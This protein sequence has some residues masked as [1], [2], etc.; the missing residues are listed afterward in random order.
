MSE[1]NFVFGLGLVVSFIFAFYLG[2]HPELHPANR[3]NAAQVAALDRQDAGGSASA[4]LTSET[5]RTTNN[6]AIEILKTY[7]GLALQA[8]PEAD[9]WLI[10]YGHKGDK[11]HS[12]MSITP[13]KAERLLRKDLKSREDFVHSVVRVPINDNE[14]SA[15]VILSYNIGNG[16]FRN[17]TVLRELNAGNRRSAADAF[18]MW[19]KVKRSGELA[20]SSQLTKRR[21]AERALF[22]DGP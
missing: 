12:G 19:N 22:L 9:Y 6:A 2:E 4:G 16:A 10:G 11:V 3:S 21:K 1:L 18:L 15:L 8:Y 17:S 5:R 7:E 20:E 14:F 13:Q